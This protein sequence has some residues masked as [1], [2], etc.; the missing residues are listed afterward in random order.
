M[1]MYSVTSTLPDSAISDVVVPTLRVLPKGAYPENDKPTQDMDSN[2]WPKRERDR[3]LRMLRKGFA[4]HIAGD[5]HLGS[6]VQ[7]GVEDWGDAAFA[8]CVPSVSNYFPRRWFPK[9]GPVDWQPGTPRNLG[10]FYDGFGNKMTVRAVANPY[11]SG[12]EPAFLYDRAAGYGL[13]KMDRETRRIEMANWPRQVDPKDPRA[14]S[15]DGW[16]VEFN[17]LDNYG[18]EAAAFLPTIEIAGLQDPLV[19]VIDEIAGEVVYTLRIKGTSFRP[20]VFEKGSY[21]VRVGE[22][23]EQ[24]VLQGLKAEGLQESRI[25]RVEC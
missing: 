2:G 7:Y 10:R 15:Y 20:K 16:P 17:Q 21:T 3:I 13:V 19:Q 23:D 8:L 25:V 9:D 6:T 24:K 4:I 1:T 18:K 5:Q 22:G 11:R 12:L 14:K